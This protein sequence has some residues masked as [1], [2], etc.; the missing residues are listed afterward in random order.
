MQADEIKTEEIKEDP[1]TNDFSSTDYVRPPKLSQN[2]SKAKKFKQ[3]EIIWMRHS[4]KDCFWPAYIKSIRS[5]KL[6]LLFVEY[7][8]FTKNEKTFSITKSSKK[9]KEFFENKNDCFEE[10]KEFHTS[11]KENHFGT[12]LNQFTNAVR[13]ASLYMCQFSMNRLQS[14]EESMRF[15]ETKGVEYYQKL[16]NQYLSSNN[17]DDESLVSKKDNCKRK[18]SED[19]TVDEGLKNNKIQKES[20]ET[21]SE[22]EKMLDAMFASDDEDSLDEGDDEKNESLI[23]SSEKESND[24]SEEKVPRRN[25][26]NGIADLLERKQQKLEFLKKCE[27]TPMTR[28]MIE[29]DI[30]A[31]DKKIKIQ[32]KKQ[33]NLAKF[34]A[35]N[36]LLVDYITLGKCDEFLLQIIS[37]SE[38]SERMNI[39]KKK[40][41]D[42]DHSSNF[43]SRCYY[44]QERFQIDAITR[45]LFRF[46]QALP[47]DQSSYL[48]PS[49]FDDLIFVVLYPEV[50]IYAI[51]KCFRRNDKMAV[52]IFEKG[53]TELPVDFPQ[54]TDRD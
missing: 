10:G 39:Y 42:K 8:K 37:E 19:E 3:G 24:E 16:Y 47:K 25:E 17:A 30:K 33:T 12:T 44:F 53:F 31:L 48:H 13:L 14:L 50:I 40:V 51:K 32:K 35:K 36:D 5:K 23:F 52:Q 7:N 43:L 38:P 29:D 21:K 11:Q 1:K 9:I 4:S 45:Y 6:H 27:D 49:Y 15:F 2:K 28:Q 22:A 18:I 20:V 46:L 26:T 54:A 41:L 34:N